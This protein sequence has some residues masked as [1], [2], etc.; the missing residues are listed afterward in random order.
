MTDEDDARLDALLDAA[1]TRDGWTRTHP[2]RL[3]RDAGGR[4]AVVALRRTHD[5]AWTALWHA[6]GVGG[7]TPLPAYSTAIAR[8]R[9]DGLLDAIDAWLDRRDRRALDRLQR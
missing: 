3:E 1:R 6:D 9:L 7:E 4:R 8:E 2:N 5:D